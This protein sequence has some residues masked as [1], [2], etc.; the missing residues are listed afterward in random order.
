[1]GLESYQQGIKGE[2]IAENYLLEQ[3]Y[4]I[5]EKNFHSQQGEIDIIA[6]DKDFLVFVE[7]K[8]YSFRSYGSP[9]G[10]IRKSKKQSIVHAAETYLYKKKI[11]NTYCRFDVLT[12]YRRKDGSRAIELY[13]NA[14]TIN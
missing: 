13:K 14:F 5:L 12:I 7:V 8:N 6:R 2:E 9:V 10:A 4:Q 11:R 3:G 1:M